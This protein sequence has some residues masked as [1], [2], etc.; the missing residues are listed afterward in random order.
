MSLLTPTSATDN[1]YCCPN[2]NCKVVHLGSCADTHFTEGDE[3]SS[4]ERPCKDCKSTKEGAKRARVK[5]RRHQRDDDDGEGT[6]KGKGSAKNKKKRAGD[7]LK[8][9]SFQSLPPAKGAEDD[10]KIARR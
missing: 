5:R 3:L 2:L 8:P 10:V 7:P 4:K 1:R 6:G 9:S